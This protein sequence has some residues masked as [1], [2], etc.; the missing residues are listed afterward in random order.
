MAFRI[1]P[2]KP[3]IWR[4]PDTAQIG[5]ESDAVILQQ[6]TASEARLIDLLYR[7]VAEA[8]LP[9]A[10]GDLLERLKPALLKPHDKHQHLLS[11]EF[12]R[13]AFAE[14]IRASYL[15]ETDG[16][17]VLESRAAKRVQIDQLDSAGILIALALAASGVGTIFTPD[18]EL[19]GEQEIGPLAYPRELLGLPRIEAAHRLLELHGV[20]VENPSKLTPAKRRHELDVLICADAV[21]PNRYRELSGKPHLAAMFR[22]TE[23]AVT[24][25]LR[26]SP[27]LGCLDRWRTENDSAWP[28]IA[29]QLIGK[30]EYL[31]DAASALFAASVVVSEILTHLDGRKATETGA[32]LDVKTQTIHEWGWS[33]HPECDC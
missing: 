30:R 11:N 32:R 7:G 1:N 17:A 13:S 19:V 10:P 8:A 6:V 24:P 3:L 9:E 16:I 12:V 27:C 31:E 15:N 14:I 23:V 20:R 4:D 22:T 5:L 33:R 18:E 26:S 28:V 21:H 29:S 25:V 2:A